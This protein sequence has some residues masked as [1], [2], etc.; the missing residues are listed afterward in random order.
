MM[1]LYISYEPQLEKTSKMTCISSIGPVW[2]ESSLC[3]QRVAMDLMGSEDSDQT[4]QMPRLIRVF[5]GHTGH[6]AV[7]IVQRLLCYTI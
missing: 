5:T 1:V 3:T 2:S 7:F 6:F 4:E